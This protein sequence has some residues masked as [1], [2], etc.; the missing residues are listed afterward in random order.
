MIWANVNSTPRITPIQETQLHTKQK[1]KKRNI[2]ERREMNMG[3]SDIEKRTQSEHGS[4]YNTPARAQRARYSGKAS[5]CLSLLYVLGEPLQA[6]KQ[7][8]SR[9]RA[10][11]VDVPRPVAHSVQPK[12]LCYFCR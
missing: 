10:A 11:G 3:Y 5:S 1:R 4:I 6:F 8:L 12:L 2:D 9:R 7:T